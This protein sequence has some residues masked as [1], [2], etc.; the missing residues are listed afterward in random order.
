[1]LVDAG[2]WNA[3]FLLKSW[4]SSLA[5]ISWKLRLLHSFFEK[6]S[7]STQVWSNLGLCV[8]SCF[9]WK[10]WC[11]SRGLVELMTQRHKCLFSSSR[12]ATAHNGGAHPLPVLSPRMFGRCACPSILVFLLSHFIP[13]VIRQSMRILPRL[14]C[15]FKMISKLWV[16]LPSYEALE[17]HMADFS[18]LLRVHCIVPGGWSVYST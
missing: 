5:T 3:S 10:W 13:A 11:V 15:F 18:C 12:H 6:M 8:S 16:Y 1:M 2:F 9:K 7:S 17:N 4:I 14:G